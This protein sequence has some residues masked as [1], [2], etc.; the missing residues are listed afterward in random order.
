MPALPQT[1]GQH[2][3]ADLMLRFLPQIQRRAVALDAAEPLT[4][5]LAK[6]LRQ[7]PLSGVLSDVT[8]EP[9]TA[10]DFSGHPGLLWLFAERWVQRQ[11]PAWR[12]TGRGAEYLEAV[13]ADIG[14]D[15][16]ILRRTEK[17]ENLI[18]EDGA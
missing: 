7:W 3:A 6:V 15:M 17:A 13:W 8:E 10:L 9:L 14:R 2:V 4:L 12:P 11:K 18:R 16:Q 1:P 5:L